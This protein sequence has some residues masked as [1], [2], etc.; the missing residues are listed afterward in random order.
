MFFVP[1]RRF[2][3]S[4]LRRCRSLRLRAATV[5]LPA[6]LCPALSDALPT[7]D[8]GLSLIAATSA[9]RR[10][11]LLIQRE[12]IRLHRFVPDNVTASGRLYPGRLGRDG[13]SRPRSTAAGERPCFAA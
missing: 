12:V 3:A 10:S 11:I 4:S 6:L 13:A 8:R 7:P 2:V 5:L 9:V 1:L